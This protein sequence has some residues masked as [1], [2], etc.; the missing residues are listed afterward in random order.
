MK[1]KQIIYQHKKLVL[2]LTVCSLVSFSIT[3]YLLFS[4][5]NGDQIKPQASPEVLAV[6]QRLDINEQL[7]DTLGILLLGYGGAGHDGGY[8]TDAIQVAHIDFPQ[9]KITLISIPR[10]LWVQ[11]SSGLSTKLNTVMAT[12]AKNN[13]QTS[14][15]SEDKIVYNGAEA[16]KSII[17]HITGLPINYF[18]AMD[19]VGL[20]KVIGE[21]LGGIE[22]HVSQTLDDPWYPIKGNELELC[23]LSNQEIKVAHE[24]YSGFE[25]ERQFPCRFER[26]LYKKGIVEMEGGDA[27]KYIRSRHGS[28]G[29]DF[30][31]GRRAQEV[32][33]AVKEKL[34][35]LHALDNIP[36]V[37][38]TIVK[39]VQ[40]DLDVEIVQFLQPALAKAKDFSIININ[41]STENVL[42]ESRA[43]SGAFI[44]LPK[45]GENEWSQV[46]EFVIQ[47][48][49]Q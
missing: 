20:Q 10:D 36:K 6:Q 27:L 17:G 39:N 33:A 13:S 29:G 37:F 24:K 22:V 23:D 15:D 18:V 2:V 35:D 42:V 47:Q 7:P 25:L 46:R 40:T 11:L 49:T 44:L 38:N 31:R 3:T 19:F 21:D 4:F 1:L 9:A 26:V 41:L 32:L 34:F 12:E 16:V 48:I 43:S 14:D 28:S 5:S 8:L 45:E 30:D